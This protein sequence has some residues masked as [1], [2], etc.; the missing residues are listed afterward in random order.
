MKQVQP[1][2]KKKKK[3]ESRKRQ[4]HVY[5]QISR[6]LLMALLFKKKIMNRY[7]YINK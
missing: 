6:D 3:D 5:T 4:V 2:L 7:M 1:R